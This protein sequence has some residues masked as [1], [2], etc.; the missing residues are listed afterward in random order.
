MAEKIFLKDVEEMLA[1]GASLANQFKLGDT[2]FL[3]G[4]LGAG[5]TTLIKGILQGFGYFGNVKS[6]TY[7]LM[8]NYQ[9]KEDTQIYHYDLYRL[10]DPEEL[11]WMGI[12]DN[13]DGQ[14]I[15]FLEWPEKGQGYLPH[16]T[17]EVYIEYH[18]QGREVKFVKR[19]C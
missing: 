3:Y 11:E 7:T 12:R 13:F 1:Y 4:N 8:E 10:S 18:D 9:P 2:I 15:S 17:H 16:A 14:S 5:K 19:E 6:P